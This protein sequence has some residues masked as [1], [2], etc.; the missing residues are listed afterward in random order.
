M[1]HNH[2]LT[3]I[4][5]ALLALAAAACASAAEIRPLPLDHDTL[6]L[7]NGVLSGGSLRRGADPEDGPG[8]YR[9]GGRPEMDGEG[10]RDPFAQG[11]A[12]RA[13]GL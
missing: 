4:L 7:G 9:L 11:D 5:L 1:K 3:A 2:V 8:G 13:D 6:D 12:G 10:S